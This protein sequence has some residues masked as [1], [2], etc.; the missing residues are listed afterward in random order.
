MSNHHEQDEITRTICSRI[1]WP[2]R[3]IKKSD[4]AMSGP[5]GGKLFAGPG[6]SSDE[7]GSD[8]CPK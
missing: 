6:L 3:K 1:A 2:R 5:L 7:G 4:A 8:G